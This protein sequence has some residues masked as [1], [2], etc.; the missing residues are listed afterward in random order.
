MTAVRRDPAP[1]PERVGRRDLTAVAALGALAA[2]VPLWLAAA[3][4]AIGIPGGDEWVYVRG[5]ASLHATGVIDMP[6]HTAASVGQLLLVQPLLWLSGGMPW[7]F[8]A[9]G[10]VM[11]LLGVASAYLLARRFVGVGSAVLVGLLV[12]AVPGF[13]RQTASFTTDVPASALTILCLLLGVAWAR[14]GRR[15]QLVASLG[16]GLVAVSVREFALA[17]PVAV[18]VAA[19]ARSR[20]GERRPIA[21]ASVAFAA[22]LAA[23]FLVAYSIPN[24]GM[25][26]D[27]SPGLPLYVAPAF[28]TLA[29]GVLP[30]AILGVDRRLAD[31]RPAHVIFGAALVGGAMVLSPFGPFVGYIWEPNGIASDAYLSG[32]RSAVIPARAWVMSE[33]LAVLA[34]TLVAALLL[35]WALRRGAGAR[36]RSAALAVLGRIG[37]SPEAPLLLFLGLSAA[38]FAVYNTLYPLF[39]RYLYPLVPVAAILLLRGATRVWAPGRAQIFAHAGLVWLAASALVIAASSF[40]YDAARWRAGEAAVA[41]GYAPQ[42]VDAGYEWVGAHAFGQGAAG[43]HDYGLTW[44]DDLWLSFRPCAVVSNSPLDRAGLV[45]IREDPSAYRLYLLAGPGQPLYLYGSTAAGC[46]APPA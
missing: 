30:A 4:G 38:G 31:L 35:R 45:L 18:L 12:F 36:S 26:T 21:W 34:G 42:T 6:G 5:A 32:A 43:A 37:R 44:Y 16:I 17:A 27:G 13:A 8:T 33:Q 22:G 7:A 2:G 41:L 29:A 3:S 24:R 14:G 9:F 1:V 40:A 46:P 15:A 11:G 19:W 20:A 25:A 28:T 39:D 10:L 23:V